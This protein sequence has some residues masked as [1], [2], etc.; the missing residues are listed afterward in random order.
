MNP[1]GFHFIF[2][3]V[4]MLVS[5]LVFAQVNPTDI[6]KAID[7]KNLKHPYLYFTEAEKPTMLQRIQNDPE[8]N[9]IFRRL[10]AQA[11]MWLAMPVDKNIPVQGKNTRAGWSEAD[12]DGKYGKYYSTNLN[13]AFSL[14]FMY[15]MTG[16]QKYADKAF[17]FADAFCD[18]TTWT[19]RAHE[20]P[21]I[22]SR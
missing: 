14:A 12:N 22:Y 4:L 19:Q 3:P 6:E 8:S 16:E 2:L 5:Q 17:E 11:R 9:D 10:E 13:N 18:L 15:Q 1:K 21:I 7:I 20:F